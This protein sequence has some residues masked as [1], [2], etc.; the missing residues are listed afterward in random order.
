MNPWGVDGAR[1][2]PGSALFVD[3]TVGVTDVVGELD[4]GVGVAFEPVS[5]SA[6]A[7]ATATTTATSATPAMRVARR[8]LPDGCALRSLRPRGGAPLPN[9]STTCRSFAIELTLKH[10]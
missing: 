5:V 7:I 9:T 1:Y 4:D 10:D 3:G 8:C 2:T 6:V